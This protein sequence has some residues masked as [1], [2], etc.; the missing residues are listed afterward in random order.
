MQETKK[1]QNCTNNFVIE[2]DDFSFYEKMDVPAPT[3]CPECRLVRRMT[4]S[5]ELALYKRTCDLTG[6]NII[7]V[8]HPENAFPVYDYDAWNTDRWNPYDYGVD[9][10]FSKPFFEQI[11]DLKKVVPKPSLVKQGMFANSEYVNRVSDAKNCYMLFR[12]TE[13]EDVMY[14]YISYECKECVDCLD[15][16]ACELCYDCI[17]C[18]SCYNIKYSQ[19]SIDCRDSAFLFACSNCHDCFGCVNLRNKSYCIFNEQYTKAEYQQKIETYSIDL[20]SQISAY[21]V[22]FKNFI[23]QKPHRFMS[24]TQNTIVSGNWI[25]NSKNTKKS[26]FCTSTEDGKYLFNILNSKDCMDYFHWG[27]NSELMYEVANTGVNCSEVKFSNDSWSSS[28]NI[29]YC[30][31]CPSSTNCFGC[32]GLRNGE[33]SIL[34]KKYDKEEYFTLVEKIKKHMHNMPYVDDFGRVYT[35]GEFFPSDLS[36]FAYNETAA[37]EFFPLTKEQALYKGYQWKNLEQNTYT[38]TLDYSDLPECIK[39]VED[40]ILDEIIVCASS[41]SA[42]SKGAFRITRQELQLYRKM[43][44]PLPQKSFLVRHM[45]RMEKLNPIKLYNRTTA[46]GVDVLTSYAPDRPETILSEE[47]Y[48]DEVM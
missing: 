34:N 37:Q 13:N 1:C 29:E 16:Y 42:Y 21:K 46:D 33:Y 28:S 24:G 20:R 45:E 43:N 12:A 44:V 35:Y 8:Y 41:G 32:V 23:A 5:N 48:Q 10:N 9:I 31:N 38:T 6:K 47:G 27:K 7:T 11:A 18:R 17:S 2:P 19:D 30:D 3:F 36:P 4:H 26:F 22:K 40:S 15:I 14:T 25:N 39:D